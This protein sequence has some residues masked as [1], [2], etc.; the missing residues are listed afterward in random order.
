MKGVYMSVTSIN[1][2]PCFFSRTIRNAIPWRFRRLVFLSSL[3]ARITS[4]RVFDKKHISQ[5]NK[6]LNLS[7]GNKL[8]NLCVF[9]VSSLCFHGGGKEFHLEN[10]TLTISD[11]GSKRIGKKIQDELIEQ[12]VKDIPITIRYAK[13]TQ[14]SYDVQR[15]LQ[16]LRSMRVVPELT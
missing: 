6:T 7:S 3:Y 11:L 13:N 15:F 9:V 14:A 5:L 8:P 2:G 16:E 10:R 4:R 12:I 1:T